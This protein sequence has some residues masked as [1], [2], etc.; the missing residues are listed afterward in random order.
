MRGTLRRTAIDQPASGAPPTQPRDAAPRAS[1]QV[2]AAPAAAGPGHRRLRP[3]T[4][5]AG[6]TGPPR[7]GAPAT[8]APGR[9][10]PVGVR[11]RRRPRGDRATGLEGWHGSGVR[12]RE[13]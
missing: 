6:T 9:P 11:V 8:V 1:R 12:P 4:V 13:G 2:V 10:R 3:P 5:R 7:A